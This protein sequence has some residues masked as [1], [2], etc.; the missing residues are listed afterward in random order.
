MKVRF[1]HRSPPFGE[2]VAESGTQD[3]SFTG[4]QQDLDNGQMPGSDRHG[5]YD[6]PAREYSPTQSRW[7]THDPA[8]LA[9]V[10][11]SNPQTWNRYSYA[12]N[13]P[14]EY[15]DPDGRD[16]IMVDFTG[17][18]H[19]FGHE[20]IVVVR[21]DGTAEYARFGPVPDGQLWGKGQVQTFYNLG[22]VELGPDGA[23]TAAAFQRIAN[24]VAFDEKV[25]PSS[26]R[27]NYFA[28]TDAGTAAL[29]AYIAMTQYLSNL[30]R[31]P[32]YNALRCNCAT[33]AVDG[34]GNTGALPGGTTV[35]AIPNMLY[36]QLIIMALESWANGM[37]VAPPPACV[38]VGDSASGYKAKSCK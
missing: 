29:D 6:F 11:P 2:A 27:M 16:A 9:A 18:A 35:S 25:D 32:E 28:T 20:G 26:V 4:Q 15:V 17:M 23:P 7:W 24:A 22:L 3:R 5:S 33:Y 34:L 8:G 19:G 30:G 1:R 37:I 13:S 14:L 21:P 36:D 38:S 31:L 10:D 12:F